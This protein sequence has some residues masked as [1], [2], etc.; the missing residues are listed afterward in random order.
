MGPLV[1]V[2]SLGLGPL[3]P[4]CVATRSFV[5]SSLNRPSLGTLVPEYQA[6]TCARKEHMVRLRRDEQH[7]FDLGGASP[8]FEPDKPWNLVWKLMALDHEFWVWQL[9]KPSL[10]I[11]AKGASI[12]SLLDG[13]APTTMDHKSRARPS[14]QADEGAVKRQRQSSQLESSRLLQPDPRAH[15]TSDRGEF[16]HNRKGLLLCAEFQTGHAR[17]SLD[18]CQRRVEDASGINLGSAELVS[19]SS[20]VGIGD[21]PAQKIPRRLLQPGNVGIGDALAQ[22]MPRRLLQPGNKHPRRLLQPG[23]QPQIPYAFSGPPARPDSFGSSVRNL[24]ASVAE[25]DVLNAREHDLVD[26]ENWTKLW[27][28]MVDF[29]AVLLAPPCF[30]FS[31][32]RRYDHGPRPLRGHEGR[33]RYGSYYGLA[34]L[35]IEECKEVKT[36]P[37]LALRAIAIMKA[38]VASGTPFIFET[39]WPVE[40][41]PIITLLDEFSPFRSGSII[42]WIRIDQC[43][44]GAKTKPTLLVGH[45]VNFGT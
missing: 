2:R 18:L 35:T 32:A 16:T 17:H 31:R 36:G 10:T 30:T 34:D 27:S 23:L 1:L 45:M 37:L 40:G 24:G 22:K 12:S 26:Q 15:K 5:W 19:P 21:A 20:S 33:A 8:C 39:P 42:E 11:C 38:C 41:S 14:D 7:K 29:H 43:A 13:D 25:I 6:G 44:F 9:E 4:G 3:L 28:R